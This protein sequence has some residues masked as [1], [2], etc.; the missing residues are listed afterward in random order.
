[1]PDP[2]EPVLGRAQ[3][4]GFFGPRPVAEQ[5]RHAEQLCALAL[6]G[7]GPGVADVGEGAESLRF[8]DLGS[9]G[10]LPGL[11][12]ALLEPRARG[13]LLDSQRRR[14]DFLDEAVA[15]LGLADRLEVVTARS[16][17]A[18]R[19]PSHREGYGL[20]IARSFGS[21]AVTAECGVAF[22]RPAGRLVV[23]EPP[24]DDPGRWPPE[25]LA[26]LGLTPPQIVATDAAHAALLHRTGPLDDRWPRPPGIP[27]KRPL[28]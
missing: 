17:E 23:S 12:L 14:T 25:P 18:A 10:G 21:P 20:V 13:T 15:L 28:W 4:L 22:L 2:L 5:R 6:R 1:V 7:L 9:G 26:R 3:D 11:V 27:N 8:L 24:D 19:D 16:E